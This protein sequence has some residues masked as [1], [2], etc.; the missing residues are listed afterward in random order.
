MTTHSEPEFHERMRTLGATYQGTAYGMPDRDGR[1]H[2][3]AVHYFNAS[4]ECIGSWS[5]YL[6]ELCGGQVFEPPHKWGAQN[7][8]ALLIRRIG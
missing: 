4:D 1:R 6:S 8:A 2:P 7:I 5:L 3:V